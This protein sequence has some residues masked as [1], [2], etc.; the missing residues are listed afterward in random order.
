[1]LRY[2]LSITCSPR[3]ED[4][5]GPREPNYSFF[6]RDS[7]RGIIFQNGDYSYC[8]IELDKHQWVSAARCSM[9]IAPGC[10]RGQ[11]SAVGGSSRSSLRHVVRGGRAAPRGGRFW[12]TPSVANLPTLPAAEG[13]SLA[14]SAIRKA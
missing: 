14:R 7:V 3:L 9:D 10:W 5:D 12:E 4:R 2:R 6:F 1:M 13:G 11:R 8:V